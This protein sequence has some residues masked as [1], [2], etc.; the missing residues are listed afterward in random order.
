[1]PK[2]KLH[3]VMAGADGKIGDIKLRI[4]SVIPLGLQ[5]SFYTDDDRDARYIIN[6]EK[7]VREAYEREFG[8]K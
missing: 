3:M 5:V 8:E 4:D 1:M 7:F 2:D 6:V